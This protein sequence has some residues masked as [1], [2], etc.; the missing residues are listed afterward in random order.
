VGFVLFFNLLNFNCYFVNEYQNGNDIN[1]CVTSIIASSAN[2]ASS[3][4]SQAYTNN[5]SH[6]LLMQTSTTCSIHYLQLVHDENGGHCI[7][8]ECQMDD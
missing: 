1:K 3:K 7:Q 8:V 2:K 5:K 4:K 6:L